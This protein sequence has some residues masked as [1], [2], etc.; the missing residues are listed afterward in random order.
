MHT[1]KTQ[2]VLYLLDLFRKQGYVNKADFLSLIPVSEVTF[3]RYINE[4]RCYASN[5][6]LYF[7][8]T[9]DPQDGVYRLA[10]PLQN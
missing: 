1:T 3:R 7:E 6:N 5:F 4:L 2:A 9:Y 10:D 8:I